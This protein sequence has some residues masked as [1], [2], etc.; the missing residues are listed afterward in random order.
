MAFT[1]TM[2]AWGGIDYKKAYQDAK[3]YGQLLSNIRWSADYL[4]RCHTKQEEFVVQ[5]FTL[6]SSTSL[7]Y[8]YWIS[9]II[10]KKQ[11]LYK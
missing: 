1:T 9:I 8:I 3:E 7:I 4:I 11:K 6:V 2:L 5:V 10:G